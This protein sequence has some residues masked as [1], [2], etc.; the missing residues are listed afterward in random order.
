MEGKVGVGGEPTEMAG[1]EGVGGEPTEMVGTFMAGTVG[2]GGEPTDIVDTVGVG[3]EPTEIAG[4]TM[5][6]IV[7]VRGDATLIAGI[8][9]PRLIGLLGGDATEILSAVGATTFDALNP[10]LGTR[11]GTIPPDTNARHTVGELGWRLLSWAAV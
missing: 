6:A 2:V 9:S 11:L 3:V 10:R 8:I 4:I 7:D 5:V 1:T